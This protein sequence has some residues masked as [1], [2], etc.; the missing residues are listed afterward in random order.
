MPRAKRQAGQNIRELALKR[1]VKAIVSFALAGLV[2]SLPFLLV[3]M[4]EIFLKQ[5]STLN[6]S[7]I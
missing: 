6:P 5:I 2:I 3:K 1:R 4:S 7:Q